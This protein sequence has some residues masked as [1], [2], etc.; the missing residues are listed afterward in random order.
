M[1]GIVAMTVTFEAAHRTPQPLALSERELAV[2]RLLS[3][4]YSNV[5]IARRLYLSERTVESHLTCIFRKLDLDAEPAFNR[6]VLAALA[7]LGS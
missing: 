7:Y 6:R 4:G 3:R 5:G 2:L 1:K